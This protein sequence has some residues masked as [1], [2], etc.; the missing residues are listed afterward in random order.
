[1]HAN[2]IRKLFNTDSIKLGSFKLKNGDISKY[3]FN[4]KNL[5]SY[6]S[7][8]KEIGDIIYK[9]L[10]DFDIICGIPHGGMPIACYISTTYNKPMIF[11]RDNVKQYGTKQLI[12]GNFSSDSR[13]VIID[14]VITTGLSII[15]TYNTLKNLLN[16]VDI[17]VIID[18]QQYV[19]D[20]TIIPIP[21]K[22]AIYKNDIVKC[23]L[24]IISKDK[25]S[26]LCFS[27]DIENPDII[28]DKLDKIGKHIVICKIHYDIIDD[29]DNT[30]I[31]KLIEMSIKHNFLIME[32]RKF[33]DISYIVHKQYKKYCNWAD[34][35][36]VHSLVTDDV[37]SKLSGALIIASM[38]N[39]NYDLSNNAI[40]LAE[41][42]PNNVI[43]YIT[44]NRIKNSKFICMTPGISLN[45]T[46]VND[47]KYRTIS[48]I[49]TDYIIVGRALYN[50]DNIEEDVLKFLN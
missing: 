44:Q 18:R 50:S 29:K 48:E 1:M 39:N 42:N 32:D 25:Q 24:D 13:C 5:I 14:D 10:N 2:L 36:T 28:L 34:F 11:I 6:P 40:L 31:K 46:N 26:K 43:G 47:Q 27:P 16:V 20:N 17:S 37:I 33:I 38:S 8:I 15:N 4:M 49:D 41:N 3:Y 7:I 30:F 12:E 22:A 21:I 19:I 45:N 23:R 35:V 9:Q